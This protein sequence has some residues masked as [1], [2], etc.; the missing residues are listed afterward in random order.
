[1]AQVIDLTGLEALAGADFT[2]AIEVIFLISD[3][4]DSSRV[5]RLELELSRKTFRM[6]CTPVVNLFSQLA[7]PIQLN[8]RA[9]Y[10]PGTPPIT[11]STTMLP[12]K[13]PISEPSR[14]ETLKM[15]LAAST[16]PAPCMFFTTTPGAPGRCRPRCRA[17]IL[18]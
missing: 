5:Q 10:F 7:E 3:V 16:L 13:S 14:G 1:M 18:A 9:S 2:D 8:L 12:A 15:W 4:S 11:G 6:G 17:T